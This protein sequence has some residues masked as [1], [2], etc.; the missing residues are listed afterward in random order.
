VDTAIFWSHKD[1]FPAIFTLALSNDTWLQ[2]GY[3]LLSADRGGNFG[4]S[5]Y[6]L[7]IGPAGDVD[8][9]NTPFF[10]SGTM[11]PGKLLCLSTGRKARSWTACICRPGHMLLRGRTT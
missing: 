4:V 9:Q 11:V 2:T 3:T 7:A 1:V 6:C 10:T 8:F 5:C